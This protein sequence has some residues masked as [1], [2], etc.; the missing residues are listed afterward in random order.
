[1]ILFTVCHFSPI[2]ELSYN[3]FVLLQSH[4]ELVIICRNSCRFVEI[5]PGERTVAVTSGWSTGEG[6]IV[7]VI[8]L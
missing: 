2:S 3:S 5:E 7:F 4:Q 1:M 6:V 8:F